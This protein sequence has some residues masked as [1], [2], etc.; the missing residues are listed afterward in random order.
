MKYDEV[1]K[2]PVHGWDEYYILFIKKGRQVRHR[3][4]DAMEYEAL[5]IK[6]MR[7][8]YYGSKG[9]RKRLNKKLWK[10]KGGK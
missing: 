9:W 8:W 1:L 6:A 5:R 7:H 3:K 2:A 10:H 4:I